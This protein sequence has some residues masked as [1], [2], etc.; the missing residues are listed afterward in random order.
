[1]DNRIGV[2]LDLMASHELWGLFFFFELQYGPNK[3]DYYYKADGI[4][5]LAG[6]IAGAQRI[7]LKPSC[8]NSGWFSRKFLQ[9]L[10]FIIRRLEKH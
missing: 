6:K 8:L 4:S 10:D 2:K 1:M 9:Q 7:H 5:Q 3:R